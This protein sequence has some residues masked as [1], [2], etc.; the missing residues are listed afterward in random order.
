MAKVTINVPTKDL[1]K[2]L[3]KENKSLRSK[4]KALEEKNKKL[5][6]QLLKDSEVIGRANRLI[7]AVKNAGDFM[8][9]YEGI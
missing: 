1:E 3:V 2:S 6:D 4:N 5:K 7:E 8:E 9:D